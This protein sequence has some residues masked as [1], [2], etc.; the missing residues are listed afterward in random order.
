MRELVL[1]KNGKVPRF[2]VFKDA[3]VNQREGGEQAYTLDGV[4][5]YIKLHRQWKRGQGND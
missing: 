1:D 2:V 3:V 5:A 4:P